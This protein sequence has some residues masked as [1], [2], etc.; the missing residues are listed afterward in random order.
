MTDEKA[1]IRIAELEAENGH[2]LRAVNELREQMQNIGDVVA[3]FRRMPIRDLSD[4]HLK[5]IT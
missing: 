3:A 4:A 2:L 1:R 5:R